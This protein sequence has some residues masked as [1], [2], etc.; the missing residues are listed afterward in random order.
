M[1]DL[2]I[3]ISLPLAAQWNE[4]DNMASNLRA[5]PRGGCEPVGVPE[6]VMGSA[7]A[8]RVVLASGKV[9]TVGA[10]RLTLALDS[11]AAGTLGAPFLSLL[12]EAVA[13]EAIIFTADG[14]EWFAGGE[15]RGASPADL[16]VEISCAA[17]GRTLSAPMVCPALTGSYPRMSGE[18][19]ADDRLA[20]A[21][22]LRRTL[23]TIGDEARANGL[24]V[25]PAWAAWRLTDTDGRTIACGAPQRLGTLSGAST[26]HFSA[27]RSGSTGFTIES[28]ATV[29]IAASRLKL[30][31]GRT[32]SEFWRSRA[33]RLQVVVWPDCM[34]LQGVTGRFVEQTSQTSSLSL[35][36]VL[37]ELPRSGVP[38]LEQTIG[39]PLQGVEATLAPSLPA[40]PFDWDGESTAAAEPLRASLA[41]RSGSLTVYAEAG[42]PGMLAVASSADPLTVRARA[43]VCPGAILRVCA[44]VGSGGGWNYG[45]HHLLVFSTDCIYAVSIDG[46]LSAVSSSQLMRGGIGRTDAVASA[47]DAVYVAAA[48]GRLLRLRGSRAEVVAAPLRPV[49]LG[50]SAAFGELWLLDADGSAATIDSR[51]RASL[52]RD[53]APVCFVE[54]Q[55]AVDSAGALRSLAREQAEAVA[56]EW[57]RRIEAPARMPIARRVEWL[58]DSARAE[59]LRLALLAD[60]GGGRQRLVELTVNGEV[61][62][63][64]GARFRAP[65][66]PYMTMRLSGVMA[67]PSRICG[68]RI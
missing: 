62:A 23:Q 36:P 33:A 31:V 6:T 25:Q 41:Y 42:A 29:S 24:I 13:D 68:V 60:S 61:N 35:S 67:P 2:T 30:R 21:A 11:A 4:T 17:A 20:L 26:L 66:R 1:K 28:S 43:R 7:G 3:E 39:E 5:L 34:E 58:L 15:C 57:A 10:D 51:G 47:H 63:P 44:P 27:T 37:A 8:E 53:F 16:D 54:P 46:K 18:L 59:E 9:L 32:A 50:W 12:D 38:Q 45:R 65:R 19:T 48:D 49:A 64:V 55:M 40:E 14:P 56:V 22:A 52:R